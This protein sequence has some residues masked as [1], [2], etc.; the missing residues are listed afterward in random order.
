M[1]WQRLSQLPDLPVLL[2]LSNL[3]HWSDMLHCLLG[4]LGPGSVERIQRVV[5]T[6]LSKPDDLDIKD[7]LENF[8]DVRWMIQQKIT[9]CQRQMDMLD[10][11]NQN[12][13]A[14]TY[15]KWNDQKLK[16]VAFRDQFLDWHQGAGSTGIILI[17]SSL[18]KVRKQLI[19]VG[20]KPHMKVAKYHYDFIMS[21]VP[22]MKDVDDVH[23]IAQ[24]IEKMAQAKTKD[25]PATKQAGFVQQPQMP[26][27][28]MNQV[29]SVKQSH[30]TTTL[31][32]LKP[33]DIVQKLVHTHQN[34]CEFSAPSPLLLIL[35][36]ST[37]YPGPHEH[38]SCPRID[39][40]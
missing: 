36:Q 12:Y 26:Q 31:T 1:D 40:D 13:S 39:G 15:N 16:Y 7:S 10:P 35:A 21:K 19:A 37:C 22:K 34:D 33:G 32:A 6:K 9:S 17:K 8:G 25:V 30:D 23:E 18:E 27:A 20:W 4:E 11:Y 24:T 5:P 3:E 38:I 14:S 2:G 29:G 28:K